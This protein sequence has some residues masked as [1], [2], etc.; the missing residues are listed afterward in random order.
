MVTLMVTKFT[1]FSYGNIVD[2]NIILASGVQHSDSFFSFFVFFGLHMEV[3]R[4][5]VELEL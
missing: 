4:L 5:G 2:C 3:P 1:C